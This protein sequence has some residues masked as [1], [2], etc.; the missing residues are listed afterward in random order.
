MGLSCLQSWG[1][2]YLR[3]LTKNSYYSELDQYSASNSNTCCTARVET[4]MLTHGRLETHAFAINIVA[5]AVLVLKHQAISDQSADYYH[6]RTL[7]TVH[8]FMQALKLD[9]DF[10]KD[11]SGLRKKKLP[12]NIYYKTHLSRK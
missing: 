12:S 2:P 3:D 7:L 8:L 1:L 9:R 10:H 5:T 6:Y 11:R 4:C